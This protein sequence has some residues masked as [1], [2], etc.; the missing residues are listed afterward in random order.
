MSAEINSKEYWDE[1]FGSGDWDEKEGREQSLFSYKLALSLM[2]NWLKAEIKNDG[3]SVLD[4]GCAEGEG[5]DL[6]G[7]E[8]SS[9]SVS[10]A[11]ISAAAIEKAREYYPDFRFFESDINNITGEFDVIFSSNTLEHFE[12]TEPI[13][14]NILPH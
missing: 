10:G 5:V 6:F 8:F 13:I 11:D 14:K 7:R 3:L 2:P 4:L 1:R 12:N 9:S